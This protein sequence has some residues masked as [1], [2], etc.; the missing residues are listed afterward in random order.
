MLNEYFDIFLIVTSIIVLL[1]SIILILTLLITRKKSRQMKKFIIQD[2]DDITELATIISTE[3]VTHSQN[4][5]ITELEYKNQLNVHD[6]MKVIEKDYILEEIIY[7]G[8]MSNVYLVKKITTE[9]LWIIKQIENKISNISNEQELLKKLNHINLPKII[10]IMKD[11]DNVYIVETFIESLSL[12]KILEKGLKINQTVI[13]DW[14]KQF[15]QVLGYLHNL[16][17]KGILHCDLK[18]SNIVITHDNKLVIIDFGISQYIGEEA[19][20]SL[21][22]KYAA[23]EQFSDRLYSQHHKIFDWKFDPNIR[24][25]LKYT[26]SEKTDIYSFGAIFFEL[27]TRRIPNENNLHLLK[28]HTSPE[29]EQ[30]ILKCLKPFPNDRYNNVNDILHDLNKINQKKSDVVKS[31]LIRR[32]MSISTAMF[33]I[34]GGMGTGYGGYLYNQQSNST[35]IVEPPSINLSVG[36]VCD[37][38]IENYFP[39]G[40][41]KDID[42][43]MLNWEFE[44]PDIAKI[45][46]N[47]IFGVNTGETKAIGRF[48][49]KEI[50]LNINIKENIDGLVQISQRYYDNY[51]SKYAGVYKTRDLIDGDIATACMVSPESMTCTIDGTIYFTD[52]GKLRQIKNDT[53]TT[54]NLSPY[55]LM[56]KKVRS[57]EDVLYVITDSWEDDE[58]YFYGVGLV[59]DGEINILQTFDAGYIVPHDM[60]IYDNKI[61][62]IEYNYG[63]DKTYLRE[64]DITANTTLIKS[65]LENGCE[66][67]TIHDGIIYFTNKESGTIHKYDIMKNTILNITGVEDERH[68][69]DSAIP[70]F[71]SPTKIHYHDGKLYILDFNVI[72]VYD[73]ANENESSYTLI[74][75]ADSANDNETYEDYSSNIC[76]THSA[77]MEFVIS[78]DTI[79]ISDPKKSVIWQSNI[80]Q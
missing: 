10:D 43:N 74:G 24:K 25:N 53:V 59:N 70:K 37:I 73:L 45:S 35:I 6:L 18:P 50:S 17:P 9:N 5:D 33:M 46:D 8:N 66:G 21:S 72:R 54:I 7:S 31:L 49:N 39:N 52:S 68:F 48:R 2:S 20:N 15:L 62:I 55:H 28:D 26:I 34:T 60:Q 78:N 69:I 3:S 67:M 36:Q 77:E 13:I 4:T 61:Y 56:P 16:K 44:D 57:Y 40:T 27:I 19:I 63:V 47:N 58:G 80:N 42:V 75:Q 11:D 14:A 64:I 23:P 1:I 12:N 38:D 22:P 79:L 71:Y 29:F 51:V 41:I 32:I 30:I 76:I 65:E